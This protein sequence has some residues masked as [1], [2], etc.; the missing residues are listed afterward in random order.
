MKNSRAL[1]FLVLVAALGCQARPQGA[2]LAPTR[3][4]PAPPEASPTVA[5]SPVPPTAT[6]TLAPA[7]RLF[8]EEFDAGAS[9]W[10]FLHSN[11]GNNL[12]AVET[13]DGTLQLSLKAGNLWAL[14]LYQPY[15]YA[16]VRIDAQ[17]NLSP[18]ADGAA[19]VVCRYDP[20]LGWYEFNIHPDGTYTLLFGQWLADGVTRYT[21]LVIAEAEAIAEGPNEIGLACSGDVLTPFINGVQMRRRQERQHVLTEGMVGLS[22]ASFEAGVV[23]SYDWVAVGNP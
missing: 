11:N 2:P 7:A 12:L 19:G 22:A 15:T 1:V 9:Y 8:R 13:G 21:P 23:L 14:A 4:S 20:A 5:P 16:D 3:R 18:G 10:D 17:V 6:A